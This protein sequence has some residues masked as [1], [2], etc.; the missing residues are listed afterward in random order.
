MKEIKLRTG[1]KSKHTFAEVVKGRKTLM[2]VRLLSI[3]P[4]KRLLSH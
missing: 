3:K 2:I 4:R 1:V